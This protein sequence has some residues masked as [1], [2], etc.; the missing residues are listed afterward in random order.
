V[1]YACPGVRAVYGVDLKPLGFGYSGFDSHWEH[2]F[3]FVVFVVCCV[4]IGLCDGLI[5][6]SGKSYR[7]C[8]CVCVRVRACVCACACVRACVW[9]KNLNN[10]AA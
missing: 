4:G 6:C 5:T 9:C 3:S 1:T 7:V 8:V 2:R 10:K